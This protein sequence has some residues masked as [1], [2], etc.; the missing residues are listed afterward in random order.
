M[1]L[2]LVSG[3]VVGA[4]LVGGMILI[5]TASWYFNHKTPIPEGCKS[6]TKECAGCSITFCSARREPG[7]TGE[8]KAEVVKTIDMDKEV[9]EHLKEYDEK[10]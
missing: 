3:A 7:D 10:K 1:M 6:Q 9:Q 2:L 4:L 8:E 5:F